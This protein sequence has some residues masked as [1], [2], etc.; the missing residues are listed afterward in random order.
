MVGAC[1]WQG[2]VFRQGAFGQGVPREI[3]DRHSPGRAMQSSKVDD[4][5]VVSGGLVGVGEPAKMVLCRWVTAT[6]LTA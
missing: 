2:G 1:D 5:P 6:A 4:H 3:N